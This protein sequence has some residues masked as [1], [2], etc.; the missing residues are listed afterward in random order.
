MLTFLQYLSVQQL[1]FLAI[2][3][4]AFGLLVTE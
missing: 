2:L 4:V 1:S 3:V